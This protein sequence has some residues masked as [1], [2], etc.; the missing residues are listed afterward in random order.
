MEGE[1]PVNQK[2]HIQQL[3]KMKPSGFDP[4]VETH[5]ETEEGL[6]YS[7]REKWRQQDHID[8]RQVL[9]NEIVIDIDTET[10]EEARE[11]NRKVLTWLESEGLPN[12]VADTGGTGF[13]IHIFFEVPENSENL[14]TWKEQLYNWIK[15]EAEENLNVDTDLWDDGVNE[16]SKHLIRAVGGR[17]TD[18]ALRKTV[19]MPTSLD[20]SEIENKE[21]VEYPNIR[22]Q[23]FWKISNFSGGDLDLT[24]SEIREEVEELQQEK[25]K[26]RKRKLESD[27]SAEDDGLEACR[28]VPAQEVLKAFFDIDVKPGDHLYCPIHDSSKEGHEEAYI[29]DG[30]EKEFDSGIYNCYGDGC[31]TEEDKERDNVSHVHNAI[32]LLVK[33]LDMEFQEA[34]ET[35]AEEFNIE[36]DSE[37]V[38]AIDTD[39]FKP[40]DFR[41]EDEEGNEKW[42]YHHLAD[43]IQKIKNFKYIS[44]DDTDQLFIQEDGIWKEKGESTVTNLCMELT[45]ERMFAKRPINHVKQIIKNRNRIYKEEDFFQPPKR[46]VPFQNGVYDVTQD[47]FRDYTEE[48]NFRFKHDVEFVEDLENNEDNGKVEEFIDTIQN[49]DRKKQIL[50]EVTGLALLPDF[51]IDKAPILFGEG[52]NGKNKFVE[53]LDEISGTYHEIDMGDY[54]DDNHASAELEN[55]TLVFFDEFQHIKD[56][57]KVKNFIGSDKI[58]VRH[59]QQTGYMAKQIAT[60]VLAAN[61]L[62][63]AP[64]Q[65][66]SF[67]RR[68]EII[69]FPYKFTSKKND[70][71]KDMKS[72]EEIRKQFWTQEALNSY[73][74]KAVKQLKPLIDRQDYSKGKSPEEVKQIW[75]NMSNPVYTFLNNFVEQGKLP[76]QG[77]MDTADNII[78]DQLVEMVND[79]LDF[80]NAGSIQKNQLTSAIEASDDLERGNDQQA[81]VPGGGTKMAYTG[82]RLT[83]PNHDDFK[84]SNHLEGSQI[85]E[86]VRDHW[87]AFSDLSSKK[88]AHIVE[89][90]NSDLYQEALLFL[91]N[92]EDKES[93]LLDVIK[94]L[95]LEEDEIQELM[96]CEFINAQDS[97]GS[98]STFPVLEFDSETF[99]NAVEESESMIKD[100]GNYI[101]VS[102]W[103]SDRADSMTKNQT[104]D[105]DEYFIEPAE[106]KGYSEKKV[107]DKIKQLKSNGTLMDARHP[108]EV[109]K[110]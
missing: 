62:P 101:D 107:E 52:S 103:V 25:E 70:G 12:F 64:E 9:P 8:E 95:D 106:S 99:D 1:E 37:T 23:D 104:V 3:L 30:E 97:I 15:K 83:L 58:R 19:V 48:D 60:P 56:P 43:I 67:F 36:L 88:D 6:K 7:P 17:K 57:A 46:L 89:I 51:P 102:R 69:D 10:T 47:E 90:V 45:N 41:H 16:S 96:K 80:V 49:T 76:D 20:K 42:D 71:F 55:T 28:K 44:E 38:E 22:P 61:E 31:R 68:W 35:L 94:A 59:M 74:T 5:R 27:F 13:H 2:Q 14:Q 63:S 34:K 108:N 26:Q 39:N 72:D 91:H 18:T 65:K 87:Q 73:A 54:T 32:D 53:M 100:S 33:G 86:L 29:T 79:Y 85:T 4:N 11:E 50:K 66:T 75:N 78:K 24:W 84:K 110:I 105:I 40:E 82:L 81:Q 98:G 109:Q 93:S 92:C 21:E 77:S